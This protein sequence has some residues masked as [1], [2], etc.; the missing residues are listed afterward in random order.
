MAL[1]EQERK[2]LEQLEASLMAEDPKLADTLSGNAEV[3]VHRRRA[4]FAGLG[5][6]V[7]IA[8]LLGGVQFHPVVSVVGFLLMLAS[9]LVGISSWRRV[10]DDESG[11]GRNRPSAPRPARAGVPQM[12]EALR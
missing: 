7:G 3:R 12:P 5:F 9:A 2:L 11:I 8:V 10:G 4:A 1:S 6:I